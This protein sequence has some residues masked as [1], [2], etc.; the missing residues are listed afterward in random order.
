MDLGCHMP[1]PGPPT[2]VH[3]Q[4]PLSDPADAS[5]DRADRLGADGAVAPTAIGHRGT[6]GALFSRGLIGKSK[7]HRVLPTTEEPVEVIGSGKRN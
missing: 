5:T 4:G 1:V 3:A 2:L 6:D 7:S